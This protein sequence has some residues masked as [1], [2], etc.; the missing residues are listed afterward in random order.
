MTNLRSAANPEWGP[1]RLFFDRAEYTRR[2]Q[3]PVEQ[4]DE[5]HQQVAVS[6]IATQVLKGIIKLHP[7]FDENHQPKATS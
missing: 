6:D 3:P 5:E 1:G 2:Y 7:E 4:S